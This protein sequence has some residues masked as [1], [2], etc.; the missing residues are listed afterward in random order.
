M[1]PVSLRKVWLQHCITTLLRPFCHTSLNSIAFRSSTSCMQF[2]FTQ[3][4]PSFSFLLLAN[5]WPIFG[6][7]FLPISTLSTYFA[8]D[9]T[10]NLVA[11]Q[12]R[13]VWTWRD[14]LNV[15][16]AAVHQSSLS[17]AYWT[18][19]SLP[20]PGLR[21]AHVPRAST[22]LMSI[23]PA[24][25]H[26]THWP[27]TIHIPAA[28]SLPLYWRLKLFVCLFASRGGT[29]STFQ[30]LQAFSYGPIW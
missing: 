5:T 19:P 7:C 15:T 9:F 2:G 25:P 13:C 28:R 30:L 10:Q 20:L 24:W 26:L 14:E 16:L 6:K 22:V 21:H 18:T 3:T 23:G 1:L 29:F 17:D 27:G 11:N 8:V 12:A 4:I